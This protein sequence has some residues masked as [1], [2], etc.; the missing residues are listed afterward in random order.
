MEVE[1]QRQKEIKSPWASFANTQADFTVLRKHRTHFN[2][3]F[4]HCPLFSSSA[5]HSACNCFVFLFFGLDFY[6]DSRVSKEPGR[7]GGLEGV[8]VDGWL[9][10][11]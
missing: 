1:L 5:F 8:K 9:S 7:P 4:L 2:N 3:W 6:G 11:E 10:H